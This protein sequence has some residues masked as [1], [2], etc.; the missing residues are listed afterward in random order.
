MN[1]GMVK[2]SMAIYLA[3]TSFQAPIPP[4]KPPIIN[5]IRKQR[6]V[7]GVV[8]VIILLSIKSSREFYK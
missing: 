3:S 7:A 5:A 1:A 8:K 4:T 2:V 6:I